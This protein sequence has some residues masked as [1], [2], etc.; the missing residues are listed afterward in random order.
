MNIITQLLSQVKSIND[1]TLWN[2]SL[3]LRYVS[4]EVQVVKFS[5][6]SLILK[7]QQH[8]QSITLLEFF[9]KNCFFRDY[10]FL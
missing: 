1:K 4:H 7:K 2:T 8:K 3:I 5:L 6:E 10:I 9:K